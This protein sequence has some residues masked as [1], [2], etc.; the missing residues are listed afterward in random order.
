MTL[1]DKV[2]CRPCIFCNIVEGVL[3]EKL[4]YKDNEIAAFDDINPAAE[5]HILIVPVAHIESVKTITTEHAGLLEKMRQKGEE[6]LKERGHEPEASKLG[7]H[8]P[9]FNTVDHLHLHVLGGAMKSKFRKLKYETGRMWYM[10]LHQLQ[11]DLDK[12]R[13]VQGGARL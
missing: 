5:T 9:P 10:D 3:P 8:V 12:K 1:L 2:L 7:F 6:L 4:I 13:R 11:A